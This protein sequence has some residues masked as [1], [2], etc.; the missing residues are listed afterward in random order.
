MTTN[1]GRGPLTV[2]YVTGHG[3]SGSTLV[4]RIL[5]E[6]EGCFD[7]GELRWLWLGSA[8]RADPRICGCGQSHRECPVW[9]RVLDT[10]APGGG[11]TLEARLS[12][13]AASLC[14]RF[15]VRHTWRLLSSTRTDAAATEFLLLGAIYRAIQAVTGA[16]VIVDKS[17][18]PSGAAALLHVDGIVPV[19]VHLVRDPRAVAYSWRRPKGYLQPA[20]ALATTWHWL[21][22]NVAAEAVRRRLPDASLL[23]RYEDLVADPRG[24]VGRLLELA[25]LP[26]D[27]SPVRASGVV[28]GANHTMYGN[29]DRL[30]KGEVPIRA[31][32]R[33]RTGLPVHVAAGVTALALPML[34]RYGY[35]ITRRIRELPARRDPD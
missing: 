10:R 9:S 18:M 16:T 26:G 17:L 11:P 30:V 15:R 27:E 8:G 3:R 31:D 23:L 20:G 7:A 5:N 4:G 32:D 22:M 14:E 25:G 19:A 28:L 35:P 33:W 34:R 13:L 29:P 6:V 21:F 2:L 1:G 24:A 12:D